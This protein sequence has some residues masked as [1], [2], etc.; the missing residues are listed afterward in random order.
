MNGAAG[1]SLDAVVERSLREILGWRPRK[2]DPKGFLS[3]LKQSFGVK[4]IEGR[5]EWSWSP[6]SY[7]VQAD[8]GAVTGAQASLLKRAKAAKQEALPLLEG[9]TALRT[10][11]DDEDVEASRAI[12]ESNWSELVNEIGFT[13]GPRVQRIDT[14]FDS[15]LGAGYAGSDPEAV[16]GQLGSLRERL[17]LERAKVNTI[18]EEQN[19]TNFLILA[20]Y[21]ISLYHSWQGQA[22]FLSRSGTNEVYLGTQITLLN[23]A[24]AALGESVHQA[25]DVLDSVFIGA[26][27]RETIPLPLGVG[28][29]YLTI[30]ELLHWAE[31]VAQ[32][33]APR[34]IREGGKEG[35][36]AITPTLQKLNELLTGAWGISRQPSANP[37][38]GYHTPR[39]QNT[40][41]EL[42]IHSG[43]ALKRAQELANQDVR[44]NLSVLTEGLGE[45]KALAAGPYVSN[46]VVRVEAKAEIGW[47]FVE[48]KGDVLGR[49]VA[50]ATVRMDKHKTIT[51]RF[52]P[53]GY[54]LDFA[55]VTGG[56]L[57]AFPFQQEYQYGDRVTVVA[58]PDPG[59]T[60]DAWIGP[61]EDTS[62]AQTTVTMLDDIDLSATFQPLGYTL[63]VNFDAT[64]GDVEVNPVRNTYT[65]DEPVLLEA[66]ARAGW[67]FIGWSGPQDAVDDP[68]DPITTVRVR[69]NA[70]VTAHF[71]PLIPPQMF[72]LLIKVEGDGRVTSTDNAINC[73]L[74][75]SAQ[76]ADGDTVTLEAKPGNDSQLAYWEVYGT[77]TKKVQRSIRPPSNLKLTFD[78]AYT[79][80][81]RFE[82]IV[83]PEDQHE[84]TI[85]IIGEGRVT[86]TDVPI[87][88][89]G[90]CSFIFDHG[91]TFTL[92]A[93]PDDAFQVWVMGGRGYV[94]DA[95]SV[96][97]DAPLHIL[98]IFNTP[99]EEEFILTI[100]VDGEGR[101][102]SEG[103]EVDCEDNCEITFDDG[104]AVSLEAHADE[105]FYF[106]GWTYNGQPS[107]DL[108]LEF[109]MTDDVTVIAHFEP[110]INVE[111]IGDD[112]SGAEVFH[113]ESVQ[114]VTDDGEP[115]A[116]LRQISGIGGTIAKTLWEAGVSSVHDLAHLSEKDIDHVCQLPGIHRNN[117]VK[118]IIQAR[119]LDEGSA[120]V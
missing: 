24:L 18:E 89:T 85:E 102:I 14:L 83:V 74:V 52:A 92:H 57:A 16:G 53:E 17:G 39:V 71:V 12:I 42:A 80:T 36:L 99:E 19:L 114:Q 38:H 58:T 5:E 72:P 111:I 3:A 94:G 60:F 61:V 32:E 104:E 105:G 116:E 29:P 48:W 79:V 66:T 54:T 4:A 62:L 70:T 50:S 35:V 101:V 64:Q 56:T 45:A 78:Q 68:T 69:Q 63:K 59:W 8:L 65:F 90:K 41:Q 118:W 26:A 11:A 109:D 84:L 1:G 87:D 22:R 55:P 113:G 119:V 91:D 108:P 73:G 100:E 20:D 95:L 49:S 93:D 31:Y 86:S 43:E 25:Y 97:I 96:E 34:L 37:V 40:F 28:N 88:C 117:L 10:D 15:L 7:E 33:E 44:F 27:E 46:T 21:T 30:A 76:Y 103:G 115:W 67:Q 9:L 51:A 6:H 120:A 47:R 112:D 110:D 77:T 13:G 23:R 81:A 106:V 75:C 82:K 98:A 107:F 2:S